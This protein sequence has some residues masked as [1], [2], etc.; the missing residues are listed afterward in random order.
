MDD[1]HGLARALVLEGVRVLQALRGFETNEASDLGR[2]LELLLVGAR[3]ELTQVAAVDELHDEVEVALELTVR[4]NLDD[5]GVVQVRAEIGLLA[6]HELELLVLREVRQ[7]PFE[8]DGLLEA[9]DAKLL[10]PIHLGHAARGEP[11]D[12]EEILSETF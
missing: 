5:V 1:I 12:E 8:R 9:A 3:E 2:D 6:E 4:E 10:G 7:D 11:F